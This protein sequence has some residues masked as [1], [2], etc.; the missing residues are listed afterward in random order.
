MPEEQIRRLTDSLTAAGVRHTSEVY[1][2]ARHGYTQADTP[3]YDPVADE[4]HWAA[5]LALLERAF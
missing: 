1:P 5:L 2:G 4:R 3:A